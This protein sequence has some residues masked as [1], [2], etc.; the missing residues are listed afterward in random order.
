VALELD[1]V[2]LERLRE[3]EVSRKLAGK[4][5]F[6]NDSK[7]SAVEHAASAR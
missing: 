2:I 7:N 4:R 5:G 1:C 6:Q 3:Y